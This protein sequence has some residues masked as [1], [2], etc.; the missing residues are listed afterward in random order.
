MTLGARVG[1]HCAGPCKFCGYCNNICNNNR[2]HAVSKRGHHA[3]AQQS[4]RRPLRSNRLSSFRTEFIR[5]AVPA[6]RALSLL[7]LGSPNRTL[8]ALTT[9]LEW[10]VGHTPAALIAA[11]TIRV[12]R[13]DVHKFNDYSC[14]TGSAHHRASGLKVGSITSV[15]S[16]TRVDVFLW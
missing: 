4:G 10:P 15:T 2:P 16:Q 3:K 6:D 12:Q 11:T 14:C 1:V 7:Q 8:T 5:T 13:N 9:P